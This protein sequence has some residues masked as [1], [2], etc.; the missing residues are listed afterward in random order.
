MFKSYEIMPRPVVSLTVIGTVI[1]AP[2][3]AFIADKA[4]VTG[5]VPVAVG[6]APAGVLVGVLVAVAVGVGDPPNEQLKSAVSK[7]SDQPPLT[8]PTLVAVSS[9]MNK[10]HVPF[11][12]APSE[13]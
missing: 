11:I 9:T 8:S 12:A 2:G 7:T 6:V 4:T 5:G 3:A 10:F 1:R 13:P